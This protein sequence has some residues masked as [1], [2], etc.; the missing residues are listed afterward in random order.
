MCGA[1]FMRIQPSMFG[2]WLFVNYSKML[3]PLGT[4]FQHVLLLVL[5]RGNANMY[6]IPPLF[7]EQILVLSCKTVGF[8]VA[9]YFFPTVTVKKVGR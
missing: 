1:G 8:L 6:C 2:D 3:F 9:V 4:A 7:G 5:W